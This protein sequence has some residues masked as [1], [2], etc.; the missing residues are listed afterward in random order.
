M[1]QG[2]KRKKEQ[3][4][5]NKARSSGNE[6]SVQ[7]TKTDQIK[8]LSKNWS[9]LSDFQAKYLYSQSLYEL[10]SLAD[11]TAYGHKVINNKKTLPS[12]KD[13]SDVHAK[14]NFRQKSVHFGRRTPCPECL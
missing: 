13:Q 9:K 4:I 8:K 12:L 7:S 5:A 1:I 2:F 14:I 11:V 3:F 6:G 10:P